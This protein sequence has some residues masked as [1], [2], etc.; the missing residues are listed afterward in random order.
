MEIITKR[1]VIKDVINRFNNNYSR[2]LNESSW[3]PSKTRGALL[4]ELKM[5]DLNSAT[6]ADIYKILDRNWTAL[7]CD[8]CGR[9]V[10]IVVQVGEKPDFESRTAQL[11]KNC[12]IAAKN[13]LLYFNSGFK[14]VR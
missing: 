14:D 11:C 10:Q 5:L 12:L 8:E 9:D 6:E 13:A 4:R 3:V 1:D 7:V 2:T